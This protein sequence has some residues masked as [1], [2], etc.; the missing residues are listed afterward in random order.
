M[1]PSEIEKGK[2]IKLIN[3]IVIDDSLMMCK[4][5]LILFSSQIIAIKRW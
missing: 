1:Q 4:I 5:T 3:T 2:E